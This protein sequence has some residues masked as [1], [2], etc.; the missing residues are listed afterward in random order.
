VRTLN[1]IQRAPHEAEVLSRAL[2]PY[3]GG[4]RVPGSSLALKDDGDPYFGTLTKG[5]QTKEEGEN[6]WIK[7]ASPKNPPPLHFDQHPLCERGP[8]RPLSPLTSIKVTRY[9]GE[10]GRG[11]RNPLPFSPIHARQWK[12]R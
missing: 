6:L 7:Q 5:I 3:L 10:G 11:Y 2:D 12:A 9:K 1:K 4:N 8:S